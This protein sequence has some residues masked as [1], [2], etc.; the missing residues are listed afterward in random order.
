MLVLL[1]IAW[2][3]SLVW[4]FLRLMAEQMPNPRWRRGPR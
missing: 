3:A 2:Q 4:L 1:T